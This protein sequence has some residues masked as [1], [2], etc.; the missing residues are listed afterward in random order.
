MGESLDVRC[1]RVFREVVRHEGFNRAAEALCLSQPAVTKAVR[2]LETQLGTRLFERLGRGSRLSL[3]GE[4]LAEIAAPLLAD[5]EQLPARLAERLTR[6][7]RGPVRIGAGEGGALY[8]LPESIRRLRQ[9]YPEVEVVVRN[10]PNHETVA[11]LRAGELDFGLRALASAPPDLDYRPCLA[12]DRVLITPR[13]H[14]LLKVRRLTLEMLAVQPFVMPWPQANARRVVESQFAAKGLRYRVIL[15]AGG[16]E[17]VKRYVSL[18]VGIA[19]VP[20]CCLTKADGRVL[21]SR[22]VR[23]I[24]HQDVYGILLRRDH[25]LPQA[26]QELVRIIESRARISARRKVP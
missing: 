18:G 26:A 17:V 21:G 6:Q 22:S 14:P 24:F 12:F 19:V 11:L 20:A 23:T 3:T 13:A 25:T 5:W 15:E 8:L 9:R 10:Q 16:W 2:R 1:V 4:A 7:S